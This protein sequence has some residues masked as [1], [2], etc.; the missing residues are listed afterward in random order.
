M[1]MN[2]SQYLKLQSQMQDHFDGRYRKIVDCDEKLGAE[3]EKIEGLESRLTDV[4]IEQAKTNTRL[5]IMIGILATI[6]APIVALCIK[7]LFP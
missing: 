3:N 7:L 4:C 2:H 6:A 1:D 5:S